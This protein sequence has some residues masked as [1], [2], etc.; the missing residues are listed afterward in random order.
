MSF[1]NYSVAVTFTNLKDYPRRVPFNP[2]EKYPEYCGTDID[3]ENQMYRY[4]RETL[5]RLGM[6]KENFGTPAWNPL[7]DVVKPG[8]NV[9]VKPNT[10]RHF[11]I[12][13]KNIFSIIV[14]ASVMR[15]MLDYIC[16]ALKGEG[17]IVIGDAQVIFGH[18]DEAMAQAQIDKLVEWYRAHTKIPIELF[19]LRVYRAVPGWAGGQ[20][21]RAKVEQ[22]PRGY[23]FINLGKDSHFEGLDPNTFR[24]NIASHK[25]MKAHHGPGKH[26][27]LFPKSVLESDV[28]IGIP[29]YKTH[30]RT[31]VT[32]ALKNHMGLPA[33]K[34]TLPH[35]FLGS[36][37]EGGDQYPN[38]SLRKRWHTKVRDWTETTPYMG[39]K[40]FYAGIDRV[41]WRSRYVVPFKDDVNQG[42][43]FGNDTLW[44]TLLDINRCLFYSDR[45]GNLKDTVQKSYFCMMDGIIGGEGNGPISCDP[46]FPGVLMAGFNPVALDAVGTILMGFDID[47]VPLVKRGLE[48]PSSK[49]LFKGPRDGI[50]VHDEDNRFP[51]S[52]FGKRRNLKYA[53]HPNWVGH[54]ERT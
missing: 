46:V 1:D 35:F 38:P 40:A 4:V 31:A 12:T 9:F 54:I 49:P 16:I 32:M 21:D 17:R 36:P 3:P 47:K 2:P 5:Q 6:D 34:D 33:W 27:Y 28:I 43:W 30:R 22:D 52:E 37:S 15:P 19:D 23:K 48:Q 10:V 25:H 13:G 20:R 42:M 24:I 11:H 50:Y 51:L 8:M 39:L 7:K 41:I 44:R 29:K 53:P 18:F 26:E 45:E 14:H